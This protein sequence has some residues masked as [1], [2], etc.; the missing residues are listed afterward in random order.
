MGE[1]VDYGAWEDNTINTEIAKRKGYTVY[2]NE[3]LWFGLRDESGKFLDGRWDSEEHAWLL[4]S[5]EWS[6]DLRLAWELVDPRMFEGYEPAFN[7]IAYTRD[8]E[9]AAR[10]ICEMW[11]EWRDSEHA[12]EGE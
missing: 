12:D 6:T 11:L 4:S 7:L 3:P 10:R 5:P 9:K 2:Y 8:P 1:I